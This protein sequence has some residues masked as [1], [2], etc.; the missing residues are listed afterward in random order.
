LQKPA[1]VVASLLLIPLGFAPLFATI[2]T[3]YYTV[4]YLDEEG[5]GRPRRTRT[6]VVALIA[7]FYVFVLTGTDY[8]SSTAY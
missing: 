1:D 6:F 2:A 7:A 4:L 5:G 3:W 8:L